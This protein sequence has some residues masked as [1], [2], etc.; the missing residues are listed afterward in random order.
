MKTKA[1]ENHFKPSTYCDNVSEPLL[2]HIDELE[3]EL[4]ALK[5]Q[6]Q[7]LN[8]ERQFK[9]QQSENETMLLPWYNDYKRD[10]T[11]YTD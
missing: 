6:V 4:R 3:T 5:Q 2:E 8:F 1:D 10:R 9:Q 11:G 7:A